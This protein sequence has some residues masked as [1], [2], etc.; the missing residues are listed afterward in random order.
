M[1]VS[2]FNEGNN[3]KLSLAK[4]VSY[5]F[6]LWCEWGIKTGIHCGHRQLVIIF[7]GM[8]QPG[9]CYFVPCGH[10]LPDL[11]SEAAL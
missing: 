1:S 3:F 5:M 2:N 4:Q 7:K 11:E 9:N 6:K 8:F 10:L